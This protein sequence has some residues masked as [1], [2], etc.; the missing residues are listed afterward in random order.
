MRVRNRETEKHDFFFFYVFFSV[1][2]AKDIFGK[3]LF[4]SFILLTHTLFIFSL[5]QHVFPLFPLPFQGLVHEQLRCR[6]REALNHSLDRGSRIYSPCIQEVR[7]SLANLQPQ[8]R[9]LLSNG[10]PMLVHVRSPHQSCLSFVN[11]ICAA[12]GLDVHCASV[13]SCS[14][15]CSSC[16]SSSLLLLYQYVPVF[17]MAHLVS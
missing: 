6:A 8:I 14:S 13:S 12:L 15:S 9:V 3:S 7:A 2:S 11:D 4:Q 5:H 10:E 17:D 1:S 16:S